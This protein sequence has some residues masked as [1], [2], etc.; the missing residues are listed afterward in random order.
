MREK[1]LLPLWPLLN[2]FKRQNIVII[3]DC[4]QWCKNK[5]YEMGGQFQVKNATFLRKNLDR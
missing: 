1:V 2:N 4:L 3:G 5:N